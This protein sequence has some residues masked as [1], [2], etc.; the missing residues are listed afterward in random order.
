MQQSSQNNHNFIFIGTEKE[1]VITKLGSSQILSVDNNDPRYRYIID[2]FSKINDDEFDRLLKNEDNVKNV[3][4]TVT[5]T[6]KL[7]KIG[8]YEL[9]NIPVE[10]SDELIFSLAKSSTIE[11][12][13]K[14]FELLSFNPDP[15]ITVQLVAFLTHISIYIDKD[16]YII[17]YKGVR[18]DY[19]DYHTGTIKNK[20]GSKIRMKRS[21]VNKNPLQT[22]SYGLHVGGADYVGRYYSGGKVLRVAINPQHVVSVPV[23][24]HGQKMRCC[25]YKVLEDVTNVQGYK[26]SREAT[27]IQYVIDD[28]ST[29]SIYALL[30]YLQ[31]SS[32]Y[33]QKLF[34]IC[35]EEEFK[36]VNLRN[37]DLFMLTKFVDRLVEELEVL[38]T[39]RVNE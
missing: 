18:D 7:V 38:R 30:E 26:F 33:S 14:F 24:Y 37:M 36:S 34:D 13:R 10:I 16:G 32:K 39:F 6:K 22:C 12:L 31:G 9:D 2:N 25:E 15:E 21:M 3:T 23:D 27:K 29:S 8:S 20:V 17:G 5:G 19:Y 35:A 28:F 1:I 4:S 11:G